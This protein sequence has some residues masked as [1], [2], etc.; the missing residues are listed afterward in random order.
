MKTYIYDLYIYDVWGNA[1]D[2]FHV[3]DRFLDTKG[4]EIPEKIIHSSNK[5]LI[6]ELKRQGFIKKRLHASSLEIEGESEFTLYFNDVRR[7]VG[8]KP[9]MELVCTEINDRGSGV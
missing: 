6:Q 4:I 1:R 9:V 2:G 7:N 8:Y 3:N 5:A